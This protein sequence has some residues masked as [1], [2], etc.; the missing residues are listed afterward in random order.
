MSTRVMHLIALSFILDIILLD[1]LSK[2]AVTELLLRPEMGA[3]PVGLWDWILSAPA[4][5]GFVSIPVIPHFDFTMVWNEGVSF[6]MLQGFGIWPLTILSLVISSVFVGWIFKS[7][8][9]MESLS[10]A[11]IV[12]GAIEMS[13]IAF[14]LA[15]LRAF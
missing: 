7:S 5:V 1:Q 8:T 2:W 3:D 6:G 10:L 12:G 4:R 11:M 15:V 9:W 13:L 14:V